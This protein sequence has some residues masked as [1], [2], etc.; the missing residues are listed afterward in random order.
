MIT[1]YLSK[2]PKI[3]SSVFMAKGAVVIGDVEL[4]EEC[5]VWF[6]AVIRGDVN[7][8]RIGRR[9]NIQ[10][11][12]IIHVT[13]EKYPTVIGD[14]VTIGHGA[15]LHAC[16]IKDRALI[17]MGAKVLDRAVIGSYSLIAAGAV[18]T[19]GCEVPERTL[20]AGVPAKAIRQ[21]TA[22]EMNKIEQS[23]QNYI[24]YAADYRQMKVMENL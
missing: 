16:T 11:G 6:N 14:D 1:Q 12:A 23:A 15:I 21:L 17:G 18:I 19:E 8:I 5:S 22:E 7:Y 20:M 9:T 3:P 4:G 13:H 24:R 10:D 2:K